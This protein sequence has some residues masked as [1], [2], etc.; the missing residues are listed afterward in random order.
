MDF[1]L[2]A[3]GYEVTIGTN[4][5]RQLSHFLSRRTD[6]ST[7]FIFTD[8]NTK[9][10][11]LPLIVNEVPELQHAMVLEVPSGE[12]SK[13]LSV[14]DRLGHEMLASGAD[15][16]SLLINLGGG[17]VGDIGGF[18]ASVFMRGIRFVQV[19]TS[20][21]SMVKQELTWVGVKT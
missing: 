14:V 16:R 20:L 2:Q 12:V 7:V 3:D 11:C 9:R 1:F 10:D 21:L 8:S 17:M 18:L 15:R 13:S 6:V 19:P 4:A 5:V